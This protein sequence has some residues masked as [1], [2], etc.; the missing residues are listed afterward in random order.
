MRRTPD[1]GDIFAAWCG[2]AVAFVFALIPLLGWLAP[3]GLAPAVALGGILGVGAVRIS[4]RGLPLAVVLLLMVIWT[5]ASIIWSPYRPDELEDATALKLVLQLACYWAFT[6]AAAAASPPTRVWAMRVLAWGMAGF[7][8]LLTIEAFGGAALFSA[9]RVW[10]GDPVR[11]D[12]ARVKVAHGGFILAVLTPAAALAAVRAARAPWLIA[13]MVAGVAA[14][15]TMDADA[16]ILALVIAGAVGLAV[17]RWPTWAPRVM[18]GLAAF[19]FLF[20]PAAIW[21]LLKVGLYQQIQAAVPLSWSMRMSYWRHATAWIADHPLRGW[22]LDASRMFKPGISLHPHD[23]AL[24]YWVELGAV[25]AILAAAFWVLLLCGLRRDRPD[26]AVATSAATAAA[27]LTFG[28]ISF[29]VW[30]EWWLALGALAA[31][32]CTVLLRLPAATPKRRAER[33]APRA[34]TFAPISE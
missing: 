6:C 4:D 28:A 30:Q 10:I 24:Q 5:S 2:W 16:P 7:G 27:Y 20:A 12:I 14:T 31:G 9:V 34:S 15:Y 22:G 23:A 1:A 32:A 11:E 29:G 26:A 18:A 33:S 19:F 3:L 13:P 25:G 21:T 8:L 17:Y